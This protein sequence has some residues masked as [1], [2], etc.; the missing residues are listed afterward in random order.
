VAAQHSGA[1]TLVKNRA[2]QTT[3]SRDVLVGFLFIYYFRFLSELRMIY[4]GIEQCALQS[5]KACQGC[6]RAD[7]VELKPSSQ[8][9]LP[10]LG[11]LTPKC[12][13]LGII[14]RQ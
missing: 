7:A 1:T 2:E 10:G 14:A 9:E 3:D 12:H 4:P 6:H 8:L 13:R 5:W 11:A